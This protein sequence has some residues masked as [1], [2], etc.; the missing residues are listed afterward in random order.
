MMG[1]ALQPGA[2]QQIA[3]SVYTTGGQYFDVRNPSHLESAFNEINDVEKGIFYTL[4]LSENQPAYAIFVG[5]ALAC[6]ALRLLLHAIPHFV[7]LS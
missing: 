7:D 5:L 4:Q 6:L 2:S 1:V 3:N